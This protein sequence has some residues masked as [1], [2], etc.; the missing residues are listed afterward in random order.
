MPYRAGPGAIRVGAGIASVLLLSMLLYGGVFDDVLRE[1]GSAGYEFLRTL[2][3][4]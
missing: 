1:M 4:E 2:N 3:S